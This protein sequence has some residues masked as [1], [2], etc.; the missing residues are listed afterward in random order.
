MKKFALLGAGHIHTPGF[1]KK[2]NKRNDLKIISVWDHD[3]IRAQ[4]NA[5]LLKAESVRDYT[6]VLENPDLDAVI[7]CSETNLHEEIIMKVAEAKKHCFVEK[8]LGMGQQDS[9]R[10]LTALENSGVMFQ[11]GYFSRSNPVY[12]KLKQLIDNGTFGTI[13]RIRL[14][15]C[16]DGLRRNVF[17]DYLWMTDLNQAGVGAFGDLGTHVLDLLLWFMSDLES[18]TAT[19]SSPLNRYPGCDESGEALLKFKSGVI[20]SIAAGW[21]DIA[22]PFT[23]I[24]SGTEAH[25]HMNQKEIYLKSNNIPGADGETALKNLPE[26]LPHAFDLFLNAVVSGKNENLVPVREAAYRSTV[27]EAIYK[28]VS[29]KSWVTVKPYSN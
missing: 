12:R 4:Q 13:S 25:A 17:D 9:E 21:V 10:M 23:V 24:V 2:L 3:Q 22:Q 16:H 8:P 18:V 5:D 28:A 19:L 7:I 27:M 26:A 15:N 14:N 29:E 20:A 6:S 1:V 11:T